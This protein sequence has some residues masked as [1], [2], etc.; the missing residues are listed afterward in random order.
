REEVSMSNP[1]ER[2]CHPTSL[3]ELQRRWAAVRRQMP[4]AG[5]DALIIQGVNNATGTGGYFRWFTGISVFSSYPQTVIVPRQG[6]MTLVWHGAF[7]ESKRFD[8]T[9]L[10]LP[11]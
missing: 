11:G 8:G 5:I 9:N 2:W 4:D 10:D 7:N 3:S 6:L 1:D